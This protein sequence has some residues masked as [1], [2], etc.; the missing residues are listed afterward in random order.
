MYMSLLLGVFDIA[1]FQLPVMLFK[2]VVGNTDELLNWQ[3]GAIG[4]NTGTMV[5]EKVCKVDNT[6]IKK[7]EKISKNS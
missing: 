3:R 6:Q 5:C 7:I 1:G 2:D 4:L